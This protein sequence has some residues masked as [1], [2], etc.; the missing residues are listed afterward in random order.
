MACVSACSGQSCLNGSD[1]SMKV[2]E[3]AHLYQTMPCRALH[4]CTLP[5]DSLITEDGSFG[6]WFLSESFLGPTTLRDLLVLLSLLFVGMKDLIMTLETQLVE[7]AWCI[8]EANR[9]PF[10]NKNRSFKGNFRLN[11]GRAMIERL[12][13]Q[14]E[15]SL[16]NW[17]Y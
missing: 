14:Q 3:Y 16:K 8:K 1:K 5:R 9:I 7:F 11:T 15:L 13:S 6:E 2:G 12:G 17:D 10:L 4:V